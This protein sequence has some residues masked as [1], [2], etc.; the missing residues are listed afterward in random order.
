MNQV[1]EGQMQIS[2][3]QLISDET[4]DSKFQK[5]ANES[6]SKKMLKNDAV[7]VDE[8]TKE[9]LFSQWGTLPMSNINNDQHLNI[10]GWYF[11]DKN[12]FR[13]INVIA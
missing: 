11:P 2:N 13:K 8:T 5:W 9:K 7:I 1:S 6:V 10:S 12:F 4:E 3:N